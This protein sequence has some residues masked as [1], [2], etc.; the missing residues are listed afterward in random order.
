MLDSRSDAGRRLGALLQDE[1][2]ATVLALPPGGVE[3][4][5]QVARHVDGLLEVVQDAPRIV[6]PLG[7]RHAIVVDDGGSSRNRLLA[8]VALARARGA[9]L[10]LLAVPVL[11]HGDVRALWAAYDR[12][13]CLAHVGGDATLADCYRD[14][15]IPSVEHV[16]VLMR[17]AIEAGFASHRHG[18]CYREVS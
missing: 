5:I 4:A 13:V 12:V 2:G 1:L 14:W 3:V 17:R 8:A 6:T 7:T 10:V 9:A 11:R 16:G 18:R 15:T